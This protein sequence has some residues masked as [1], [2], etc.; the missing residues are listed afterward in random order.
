MK[1]Q[2]YI[3]WGMTYILVPTLGG[4]AAIVQG[5]PGLIMALLS[6]VFAGAAASWGRQLP[7]AKE[8]KNE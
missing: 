1:W 3:H 4:L 7:K 6:T 8:M 5:Q 2:N